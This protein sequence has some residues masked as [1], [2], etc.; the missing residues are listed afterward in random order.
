M[1]IE[2]GAEDRELQALL[3]LSLDDLD[4]VGLEDPA[5]P[6]PVAAPTALASPPAPSQPDAAEDIPFARFLDRPGERNLAV[7]NFLLR[8]YQNA[9]DKI[10]E[11]YDLICLGEMGSLAP[12]HALA[13]TLL[14]LYRRDPPALLALSMTRSAA[15]GEY[16][17]R[18]AVNVCV[19][20]LAT[21]VAS[22]RGKEA[23][24]AAGAAALV[25][26]VGM[27]LVPEDILN[28]SGKL[29]EA[30]LAEIQK[31]TGYS[32]ALLESLEACTPVVLQVAR[33][34]HERLTG[35]GYPE[36]RRGEQI[37]SEA[38]MVAVADTLAAMMHKR[39]HREALSAQAALDRV[40]KMGR[41]NFLDWEMLKGLVGCISLYP[42]GSAVELAGGLVAR[43]VGAH[44]DDPA[45]PL[46]AVLRDA[47]GNVPPGGIRRIDMKAAREE[48]IVRSL[49]PDAV[50]FKPLDGF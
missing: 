3:E 42:V 5:F 13:G 37:G 22:G 21:A 2:S 10:H 45:R 8:E 31:H 38:R 36:R 34:H 35:G 4:R 18:H 26:D 1:S 7:K 41:M 48:K 50:G 43:V 11:A 49:S 40:V 6:A 16:F 20:T 23:V 39:S 15:K 33:Q 44:A 25:A 46:V 47:K 30:E 24:R 28:N 17:Y 27:R 12:V 29:S 19:L 9:A 32:V 14:E